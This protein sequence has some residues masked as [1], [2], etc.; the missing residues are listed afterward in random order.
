VYGVSDWPEE[1][2]KTFEIFIDKEFE[3]EAAAIKAGKELYDD[4]LEIIVE[5]V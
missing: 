4:D 2:G 5:E 1:L 3:D